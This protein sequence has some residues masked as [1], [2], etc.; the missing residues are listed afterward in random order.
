MDEHNDQKTDVN[1]PPQI[2]LDELLQL[3]QVGELKK[4]EK[5]AMSVVRDFP[6][7][8]FGWKVLG[9]LYGQT[10]RLSEALKANQKTVQL[11]PDDPKAHNNLGVSFQE[12]RKLD[13]AAACYR[14]AIALRQDFAEAYNNLGVVLQKLGDDLEAEVCYRKSIS[15]NPDDADHYNNLGS[16]LQKLGRLDE[17]VI[18]YENAL[19][20]NG[21]HSSAKKNLMSCLT[22]LNYSG[23]SLEPIVIA[24]QEIRAIDVSVAKKQIIS[25]REVIDFFS[26]LENIIKTY[27]LS[28]STKLSQIYRRHS[29][30]LNCGRHMAIFEQHKVIPRFCFGCYKVQVEPN[31]VIE[32]I[33]LFLLFDSLNLQQ[34]NTQKCMIELRSEVSGFYKG[35]VYCAGLDEA[36][37]MKELIDGVLEENI[38][39][40]LS[41]KVKRG[42][43]EYPMLYPDYQ[44]INFNGSQLM[45]YDEAWKPIEEAYDLANNTSLNHN[46]VSSLL[47]VNIEDAMIIRKWID[48]AKGIGDPASFLLIGDAIQYPE[49]FEQGRRRSQ[50]YPFEI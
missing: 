1:S 34:K 21:K 40:G 11:A 43:S 42:C 28:P 35:L 31:S 24:N 50:K 4:T 13:E 27:N 41:S 9:A 12:I 19:K 26:Q 45:D 46:L 37:R 38:R 6:N 48:Y 32:L 10:N 44:D 20:L 3:Y 36:V 5:L 49:I 2:R 7:H 18:S 15:L 29:L 8:F 47:G 30:S 14:K 33:K 39:P 23:V 22:F 25:D 17:A 16:I